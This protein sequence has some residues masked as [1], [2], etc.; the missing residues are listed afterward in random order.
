[1]FNCQCR[2]NAVF[3]HFLDSA[4][5]VLLNIVTVSVDLHT[6]VQQNTTLQSAVEYSCLTNVPHVSDGLFEIQL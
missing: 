6:V 4:A 2:F 3:Q 5:K 1:M